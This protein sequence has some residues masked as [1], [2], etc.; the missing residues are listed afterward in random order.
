[1]FFAVGIAM[2]EELGAAIRGHIE[3]LQAALAPWEARHMY[4]NFAEHRKS[5]QRLFPEE[6]YSRLA[7]VKARWDADDVI[8]SNHPI[9]PAT[10]VSQKPRRSLLRRAPGR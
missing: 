8:R 9:K 10:I 4:L 1:M 2:N 3:A 6:S 5:P 7:V